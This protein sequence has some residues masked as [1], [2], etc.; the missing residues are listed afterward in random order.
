M[1]NYPL[2]ASGKSP[3]YKIEERINFALRHA[4]LY[5]AESYYEKD[6]KSAAAEKIDISCGGRGYS[7]SL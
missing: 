3:A 6:D 1:D 2:N 7:S 5:L 4:R